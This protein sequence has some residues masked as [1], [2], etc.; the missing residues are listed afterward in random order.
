[1]SK[2]EAAVKNSSLLLSGSAGRTFVK[3]LDHEV[4]YDLFV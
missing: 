1:M 2:K 4:I 3:S